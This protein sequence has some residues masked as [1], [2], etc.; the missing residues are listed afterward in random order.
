MRSSTFIAV[1]FTLALTAISLPAGAQTFPGVS[2]EER[3]PG[4]VGLDSG[5]IDQFAASLGGDGVIVKDGYLVKKWGGY[6]N[7]SDW[8]SALKPVMSTLLFVAVEE[9][10]V[11]SVDT[12]VRPFVQAQYAGDL[13][14][15]DQSMTFRHLADM[16]SGYARGEAPGQAWAYNDVAIMLYS[17]LLFDEVFSDTPNNVATSR[18]SALQFQDG[19][20][21]GSR[22]GRGVDASPRDF[23]R[24]GWLWL[25][26]GNW[27]GVQIIPHSYFDDYMQ[28]DV[29][30]SLPRTSSSGSD[31]LGVGTIGG[32]TDQTG[33]GPGI[34]GFNWWF[35]AI[36]PNGQLTW[37]DAPQDTFQ[38]NGH[39]NVEVVTVIPS[40]GLVVACRGNWGTFEPGNAGASMNAK[41]AQLA[42]AVTGGPH[43]G[44]VIIDPDHPEWLKRHG[45]GPVFISGPGDPEGFLYR[46]S[47]NADGTRNGDQLALINKLIAQGGNTIY[48][49]MVR[50]HD[51][52]GQPDHNPFVDSNPSLGLDP[53][54]L[55]QWE[56]WFTLMDQNG[57]IIYLFFYDDTA[58]IWNTGDTVSAAEQAFI[59]GIVETFEHHRNLIWVV[60]EESEEAY[61]S[62]RVRAIAEVIRQADE[63]EHVIANHHHKGIDFKAWAPGSALTQFAIQYFEGTAAQLHDGMVA[64]WQAAGGNYNLVMSEVADHGSGST[65][66]LKSWA[67]AMGGAY[68][69]VLGM[70]I[71]GTS[72]ADLGYLRILQNFFESTDFTSMAPHDELAHGDTRWVLAEPGRSYIAYTNNRVGELGLKNL[73]S[74]NYDMLWKDCVSGT[75]VDQTGILLGDGDH[76]WPTPGGIGGELV[77]W[78]QRTGGTGNVS[79]TAESQV[80]TVEQPASL[81]VTL[82]Y[83]DP[84]GPGP[85]QFTI[86]SGPDHGQLSGTDA[87][88]TYTPDPDFAGLDGFD[89]RVSDSIDDSN[90]ATI[91]INVDAAGNQ[92]PVANDM[93]LTTLADTPVGIQLA[94]TDPDGPGPYS[95]TIDTPPAH[96]TLSGVGNDR[97][98]IPDSG[99]TGVDIIIWHVSDGLDDSN[100]AMVAVTVREA[101]A[102]LVAHWM[103][104]ESAGTT[105][106]DTSG[107]GWDGTL[108][109]M[110]PASDWVTGRIRNG[111]DFDGQDDHVL[112]AG[113]FDPAD[114]GTVTFWMKP[115]LDGGRQRVLSGHDAFEVTIEADG[116]ISNQLFAAA[117]D[118]LAGSSVVSGAWVHVACTYDRNGGAMRIYLDGAE[119]ASAAM[120]DDD[121]GAFGLV[122][123]N[124]LD[125]ADH[126]FGILDDLRIYDRVLEPTEIADLASSS[127]AGAG[128]LAFT[129]ADWEVSESAGSL[130][131]EVTR[132]GGNLGEVS[133]HFETVDGTASSAGGQDFTARSE[134]LTW[135]DGQDGPQTV[136]IVIT[137]D[138]DVEQDERFVAGLS[139]PQGGAALGLIVSAIIT[140]ADDD[141]IQP[142]GG[143]DGSADDGGTNPDGGSDGSADDGGTNPAD[144]GNDGGVADGEVSPGDGCGCGSGG[145]PV[146]LLGLVLLA[147]AGRRRRRPD[148]S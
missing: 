57:I 83:N 13:T 67:C 138:A 124:R 84:D 53:D 4:Q 20:V 119:N 88:R 145:Q 3:D 122:L 61:T 141:G 132:T 69:M 71:A 8:A 72:T 41:L 18:L 39:W 34:Y 26:Y 70:D 38:A 120:A 103:L 44:Q 15:A 94:Y 87:D 102:G 130:D 75:T 27:D 68:V 29:S 108:V 76:T 40:L 9:G 10:R 97:E 16:T 64:A 128:L 21:F 19:G 47:R 50:S 46:G 5:I 146:G 109:N 79:P 63:H 85:Y 23:A 96:G 92:P 49:Q 123:G 101:P 37:P 143:N 54:I 81:N 32:G 90:I 135:T 148:I 77:V 78:V 107:N 65:M 104:D 17:R 56:E 12:L 82:G 33:H 113:N 14:A 115:V 117:S 58:R 42:S 2:W 106:S 93:S 89:W 22:S 95:V 114:Q 36:T 98:Y 142:D 59:E 30:V 51:G 45:G 139:E 74:G 6:A 28:P 110:D 126:F 55:N 100:P 134:V 133:V 66:R 25:N 52:D 35:N 105:A 116:T 99:W 147:L 31:Y 80:L 112:I 1:V 7:R 73:T 136:T 24:I 127:T 11:G 129:R 43:P 144:G 121:P 118:V 60:A 131:V 91:T 48:M 86:V 140:I 111:L 62:A 125:R 137:D